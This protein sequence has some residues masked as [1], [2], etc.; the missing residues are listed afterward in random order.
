[1]D[2]RQFVRR[3]DRGF[4]TFILVAEDMVT[5]LEHPCTQVPVKGR[6]RSAV[7]RVRIKLLEEFDTLCGMMRLPLVPHDPELFRIAL[8]DSLPDAAQVEF[9]RVMAHLAGQNVALDLHTPAAFAR[10]LACVPQLV[11]PWAASRVDFLLGLNLALL[12]A[13]LEPLRP[14]PETAKLNQGTGERHPARPVRVLIVD[15]HLDEIVKT[16]SALRGWHGL[17][18]DALLV[19]DDPSETAEIQ[20]EC[21]ASRILDR[22][23]DIILMDQGLPRTSGSEMIQR[24]RRMWLAEII[25]VGNTGGSSERLDE[26]GALSNCCKGERLEGLRRGLSMIRPLP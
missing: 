18:L 1:M 16:W 5:L 9:Q 13:G 25:F 21:I 8:S 12:T 6:G 11:M 7:A 22:R 24:I 23:A 26:V 2:L 10:T 4:G 19:E 3:H 14:D 17:Q 15:D 20:A